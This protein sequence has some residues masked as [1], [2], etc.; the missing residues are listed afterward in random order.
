MMRRA[1]G[2][3]ARRGWRQYIIPSAPRC[4]AAARTQQSYIWVCIPPWRRSSLGD[5]RMNSA[6]HAMF[7][8]WLQLFRLLWSKG[9]EVQQVRLT[10]RQN[11]ASRP[12][13]PTPNLQA[14]EQDFSALYT[15]TL[16]RYSHEHPVFC[17]QSHIGGGSGRCCLVRSATMSPHDDHFP[18]PRGLPP[19]FSNDR[20]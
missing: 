4:C 2:L 1:I 11:G 19:R 9:L 12:S 6:H 3:P 15:I 20:K 17:N 10:P 8:P 16:N 13:S 7:H 18:I 14:Q 5:S